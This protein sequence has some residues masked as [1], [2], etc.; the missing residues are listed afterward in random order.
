MDTY[1]TKWLVNFCSVRAGQ[2]GKFQYN[3]QVFKVGFRS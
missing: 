2:V 3:D 1:S